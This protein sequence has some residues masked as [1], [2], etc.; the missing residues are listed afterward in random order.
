MDEET[1]EALRAL[2][3]EAELPRNVHYGDGTPI[4]DSVMEHIGSVY[5][6]VCI[7]FPWRK[8]DTLF[9]DNMRVAHARDPYEGPRKI[10]VALARMQSAAQLPA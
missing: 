8:G 3:D 9:L 1:R 6:R 5:E 10:V 2:F 4:P 7:R